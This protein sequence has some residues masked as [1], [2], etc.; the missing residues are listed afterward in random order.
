MI[1]FLLG[2][3]IFTF[4]LNKVSLK[5]GFERLSY[6]MEIEESVVEIGER[7]HINAIIENHKPLTISFLKVIEK[8]SSG[9]S[10]EKHIYSL[11]IMPYQ[12]IKRS[13]NVKALERGLHR[14]TDVELELGDF[15]GFQNKTKA[16]TMNNR[17]TI[18]PEKVELNN[19]ISP[20]GDLYGDISI[21]RWMIDDPLMTVGIR[22]YTEGDP[23][24]YI[25]WASSMRYGELMVKKFDF[26][27]EN[28]V[29]VLLNI[30]TAKPYWRDTQANLIED[31]IKVCRSVIEEMEELK[32]SYG[33]TSNAY[34]IDSDYSKA[35]YYYPG[36]GKN[37]R[38]KFIEVLGN[39]NYSVSSTFEDMVSSISR[40]KGSFSTVVIITPKI[41]DSYIDPLNDLSKVITKTVVIAIENQNLDRLRYDILKYRGNM[42]D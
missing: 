36:T 38:D 28:S 7:I 33:F 10:E 31:S 22:E 42:H 21:K 9:V 18:L 2:I 13:Y 29:M 41:L 39:I 32:I 25:H 37:H 14:F 12:R 4:L 35:Y 19:S 11:F 27:T 5:Y 15:V 17:V 1:W 40:K 16:I 23:Q 34:N 6:R 3:I 30:E 26:T 20:V 8:F 24:K